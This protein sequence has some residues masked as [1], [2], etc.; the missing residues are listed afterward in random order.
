MNLTQGEGVRSHPGERERAAPDAL[1]VAPS[2]CTLVY[3]P[4][5]SQATLTDI[6]NADILSDTTIL[7][8]RNH[9]LVI[10]YY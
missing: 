6:A 8:I 7:D 10:Y 3:E 5:D 9:Q 4:Y 2:P 1:A